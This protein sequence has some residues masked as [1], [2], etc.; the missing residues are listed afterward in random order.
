MK[1]LCRYGGLAP[2]CCL[3]TFLHGRGPV[4]ARVLRWL[5]WPRGM[6]AGRRMG[7][8]AAVAAQ[9]SESGLRQQFKLHTDPPCR[10]AHAN[11]RRPSSI[12][13]K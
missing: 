11:P 10:A 4:R 9:F 3:G 6:L 8:A 2:L 5:R 13:G 7:E 1:R 12:I